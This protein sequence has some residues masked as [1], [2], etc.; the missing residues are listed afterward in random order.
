MAEDKLTLRVLSPDGQALEAEHLL[1][2]VVPLADGGSIGIRPKHA[3]LIAETVNGP[4]QYQNNV[5]LFEIELLA[6]ILSI[7]DNVVTILSAGEAEETNEIA[8]SPA[9]PFVALAQALEAERES[10]EEVE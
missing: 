9:D 3:P 6:G 5:E 8:E 7:R 2:V 10:V 4:I 1:K